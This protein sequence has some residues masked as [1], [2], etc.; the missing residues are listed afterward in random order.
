MKKCLYITKR[1]AV[2]TCGFVKPLDTYGTLRLSQSLRGSFAARRA[3]GRA[4]VILALAMTQSIAVI[5]NS[6]ANQKPFHVMNIKLYAYNK[7]NWEQLS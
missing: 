6:T 3:L 2:L 7:L 4:I 1:H 5:S